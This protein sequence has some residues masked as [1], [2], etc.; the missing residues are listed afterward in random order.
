MFTFLRLLRVFNDR[1]YNSIW[2][3]GQMSKGSK[4]P[5]KVRAGAAALNLLCDVRQPPL[6]FWAQILHLHNKDAHTSSRGPH[7]S[8]L[9]FS[10]LS[11]RDSGRAPTPRHPA[12]QGISAGL[13][14]TGHCEPRVLTM[15]PLCP[16]EPLCSFLLSLQPWSAVRSPPRGR[17]GRGQGPR[18][19]GAESTGQALCSDGCRLWGPRSGKR[20][21][22]LTA[23]SGA[24]GGGSVGSASDS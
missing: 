14:Q 12:P 10:E 1:I 5:G 9:T 2:T 6:P 8:S 7:A 11:W 3:K 20:P 23:P 18:W 4:N 16:E 19:A 15:V 22:V 13:G 21:H 24:P 17:V